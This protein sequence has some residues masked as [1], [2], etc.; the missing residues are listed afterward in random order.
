MAV[1]EVVE[2][3]SQNGIQ[4]RDDAGQAVPV[5]AS[6]VK[7]NLVFDLAQAFRAGPFL[8]SLEVIPEKVESTSLGGIHNLRLLWMQLQTYRS[9]PFLH[10]TQH[11]TGFFLTPA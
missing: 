5:G 4:L 11:L 6:R 10:Q 3:S 7:S 2:P 8:T 9:S 1:L